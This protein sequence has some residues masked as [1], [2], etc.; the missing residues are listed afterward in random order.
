VFRKERDYP[1][2]KRTFPTNVREWS[3]H[4]PWGLMSGPSLIT[5]FD[6]GPDRSVP[7]SYRALENF[8]DGTSC[9]KRQLVKYLF[10]LRFDLYTR[11]VRSS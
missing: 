9:R 1:F 10:T 5:H 11:S 7:S 6:Q 4:C 8:I 2:G 3:N